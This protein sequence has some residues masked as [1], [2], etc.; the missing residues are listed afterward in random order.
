MKTKFSIGAKSTKY[1]HNPV[2]TAAKT[3]VLT[4]AK[5]ISQISHNF[6]EKIIVYNS[7]AKDPCLDN[8][9][10]KKKEPKFIRL[11]QSSS[12]FRHI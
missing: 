9:I 10:K 3:P 6:I 11:L 12:C 1:G 5:W 7:N 8:I 2:K 4:V